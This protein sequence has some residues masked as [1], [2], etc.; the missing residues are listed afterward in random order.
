MRAL[1]DKTHIP[2][3]PCNI[4]YIETYKKKYLE[5]HYI[6][7]EFQFE[8]VAIY[9]ITWQRE[10]YTSVKNHVQ[11]PHLRLLSNTLEKRSNWENLFSTGPEVLP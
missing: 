10:L 8:D 7:R 2:A 3:R 9:I 11:I 6:N 5:L 1:E 4:L